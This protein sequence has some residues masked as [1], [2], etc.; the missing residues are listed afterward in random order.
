LTYIQ[1]YLIYNYYIIMSIYI[2]EAVR[3]RKR[4]YFNEE[5]REREE[6]N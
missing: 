1:K 3:W 6:K 4:K 2:Y 5:K